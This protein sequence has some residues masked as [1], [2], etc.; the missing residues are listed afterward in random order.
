MFS[1]SRYRFERIAAAAWASGLTASSKSWAVAT[2]PI[3]KAK[4]K[5]TQR[6]L[7]M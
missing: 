1:A 2:D 5:I 4:N 3:A 6:M 7:R